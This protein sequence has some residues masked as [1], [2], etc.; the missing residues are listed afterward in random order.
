MIIK[1]N[2][3]N[4]KD[5]EITLSVEEFSQIDYTAIEKLV[6]KSSELSTNTNPVNSTTINP[7]V[8][9]S[10]PVEEL[11]KLVTPIGDPYT[12][13]PETNENYSIFKQTFMDHI[14]DEYIKR[15]IEKCEQYE[16]ESK[17]TFITYAGHTQSEILV[18]RLINAFNRSVGYGGLYHELETEFWP[19]LCYGIFRT[20]E[21]QRILHALYEVCVECV[22]VAHIAPR[23]LCNTHQHKPKI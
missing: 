14:S 22:E 1:F 8:Y 6:F 23:T 13:E 21:N 17:T 12:H 9:K 2:I 19:V 4:P 18:A 20:L 10:I 3:D 5:I 15:L 7:R 11:C 16:I